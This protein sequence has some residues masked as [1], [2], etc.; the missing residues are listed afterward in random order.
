MGFVFFNYIHIMKKIVDKY[1]S[2][3]S[4]KFVFLKCS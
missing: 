3:T 2:Y 1:I 4:T